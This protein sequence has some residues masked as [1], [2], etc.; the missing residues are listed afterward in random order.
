MENQ[1]N[2]KEYQPQM[3]EPKWQKI[4]EESDLYRAQDFS[5]KPKAYLLVEFPYPSGEGLHVGHVRSYSAMD[6]VARKRRMEGENVLFPIGWDAFGL[7][8]ENYAIKTGIHPSIT[9][10]KNIA[11]YTRQLKSMGLSFDWSRQVDT[12]DSGYYKW[13]QWIFLKLYER[14]MAYQAEIPVNW[15]P[16]CKTGL[17]NEEV[18]AGNCERCGE[19]VTRKTLKQWMLAIT[20][21]ADRLIDDLSRVDFW[22]KIKIQQKEWIGKSE[23]ATIDFAIADSAERVSIFTTRTDTIFGV[24]ALVLAP[25]HELVAK[26]KGQIKNWNEVCAYIGATNKKSEFERLNLEKKRTGICLEGVLA[27]NPANNEKI[28]VWLGDYVIAAYGGGAV[29]MVPAHDARD[30]DFAR[31][32]QIKSILVVQPRSKNDITTYNTHPSFAPEILEGESVDDATERNRMQ[33]YNLVL[34]GKRCYTGGG[35]LVNSGEFNGLGSETAIEKICEWLQEKGAAKKTVHYKL[36]DWIFSRQH[37][38]GE[39]IPIIHCE[40]CGIVPV[41]ENELPVK[42]PHIEKYQPTGTGESPLAVIDEWVNVKCPKCGGAAKRETDTMPNWAGSNW[43]YVRYCDPYNERQIGAEDKLDYWLPVDWY[44][45]GMEHTTLH[46][47]YS[48]FIYKFLFD[49]GAVPT[50]EPYQK[51]T[52]Q[53]MVLAANNQKMSKSRGNVVNPDDIVKEYGADTL[54]IYELFMGPFDQAIAW[55]ADAVRGSR[56]F[57]GRVWNLVFECANNE[58]SGEDVLRRVHKLNQK[59]SGDIEQLKFNTA[60][61]AFMEFLNF[62]E[63]NKSDVGKNVLQRLVMLLAPFAPHIGEELWQKL[64]NNESVFKQPWPQPDKN[65]VKDETIELLVQVNGR[66]RD[67]IAVPAESGQAAAVELAKASKI[68]QQWIDN[69]P[70]KKTVYV[71][72]RLVNLV[73]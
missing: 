63:D 50:A 37:Y 35:L 27:I 56:K 24:T 28:P 71:E 54:R 20:K 9:T 31:R 3:I 64:D 5:D 18:I 6:C 47:L 25:E 68:V 34:N 32:Y 10:Q 17:A 51:R 13:T 1:K 15:C 23:G 69:K 66:L 44:N 48:R 61:A 8:A 65:L 40:K 67:K 53:G 26:L 4:W 33:E 29:M 45:G 42:L 19:S 59:I 73:V 46:L 36:R 22:E 70:I 16:K 43:Y 38:W 14:G 39:P 62:A 7:P 30:Y 52:S 2:K 72:G 58:N 11:N 41:P 55:S 21:Y 49:I 57:L 60:I 12:T